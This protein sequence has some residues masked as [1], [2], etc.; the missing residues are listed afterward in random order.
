[1]LSGSQ[2][3]FLQLNAHLH[4]GQQHA[5]ACRTSATCSACRQQ[6]SSQA[7]AAAFK[8]QSSCASIMVQPRSVMCQ[9]CSQ[10]VSTCR[11]QPALHQ[12]LLCL[13]VPHLPAVM[14]PNSFIKS[15]HAVSSVWAELRT[16]AATA[17]QTYGRYSADT[18]R[19]SHIQVHGHV[20]VSPS[21]TVKRAEARPTLV[22]QETNR[23]GNNTTPSHAIAKP[24][25]TTPSTCA[26]CNCRRV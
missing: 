1:M 8:G 16:T 19:H 4:T 21:P 25:Q 12:Q 13:P 24:C 6:V 26:T 2:P 7:E 5:C 9:F 15:Q 3:W 17:E 20:S 23:K 18:A 22:N 14:C 10:A 11:T